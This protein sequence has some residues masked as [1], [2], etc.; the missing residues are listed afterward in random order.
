MANFFSVKVNEI[1]KQTHDSV[2]ISLDV[3]NENLDDFKF[4]PGQYITI[5]NIN[6]DCRRSYSICS[7][8]SEIL[9]VMKKSI[10]ENVYLY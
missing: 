5:A 10:K 3:G 4:V 6:E 9:T 1:H 8:T 2:S 7:S